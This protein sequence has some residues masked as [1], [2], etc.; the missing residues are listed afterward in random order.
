MAKRPTT[1]RPQQY[2]RLLITSKAFERAR[3]RYAFYPQICLQGKWLTEHG[4]HICDRVLVCCEEGCITII[5]DI[6]GF[7]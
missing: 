3:H 7:E 4:F 2:R 6:S 1:R 5:P